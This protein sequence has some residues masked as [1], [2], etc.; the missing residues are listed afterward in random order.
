MKY[1]IIIR[2]IN[3]D[4]G[5]D[6]ILSEQFSH[7]LAIKLNP[8][9]LLELCDVFRPHLDIGMNA[10][11][12][13]KT[14]RKYIVDGNG[15]PDTINN[16][17][18]V[19]DRLYGIL[20]FHQQEHSE[21]H[22]KYDSIQSSIIQMLCTR[23]DRAFLPLFTNTNTDASILGNVLRQTDQWY[24]MELIYHSISIIVDN[25]PENKISAHI[26]E[27]IRTNFVEEGS[28]KALESAHSV[29]AGECC[30]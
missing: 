5:I 11:D 7:I 19:F 18:T 22:M 26:G 23:I 21:N 9:Q 24:F 2:A 30:D 29:F 13:R 1:N 25:V 3:P 4:Q 27:L 6:D 14:I 28:T 20:F 15:E 16:T 12:I 17:L 8:E 10:S